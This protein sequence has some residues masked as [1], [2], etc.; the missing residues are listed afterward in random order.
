MVLCRI[1]IK[2]Y[3][4]QHTVQALLCCFDKDIALYL[5]VK[6]QKIHRLLLFHNIK[7]QNLIQPFA[8]RLSSFV[9]T[10]LTDTV[11]LLFKATTFI[12][13]II[14]FTTACV[15]SN[16]WTSFSFHNLNHPVLCKN[17][18]ISLSHTEVYITV[19][20]NLSEWS[21]FF[22]TNTDALFLDFKILAT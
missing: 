8:L 15:S 19:V 22:R 3:C 13:K 5:T 17:M 4:T 18:L 14:N 7:I 20:T 2:D 12:S 6:F 10:Q 16:A 11:M 1:S 9:V 21:K